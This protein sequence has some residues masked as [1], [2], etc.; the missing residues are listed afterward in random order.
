MSEEKSHAMAINFSLLKS[1]A[2]IVEYAYGCGIRSLMLNSNERA[3][4]VCDC[5]LQ[6]SSSWPELRLYPCIPYPHKYANLVTQKGLL[7]ALTEVLVSESKVHDTLRMLAKGGLGVLEMNVIRLMELLIDVE[8]KMFAGLR[9]EAVFLQNIVTD[10]L[11]GFRMKDAFI[12]Y[13]RYINGKYRAEPGF[14][15]MNMPRLTEFLLESGLDNPL[16]CASINKIG[17]LMNPD[18]ASSEKTI[19]EKKFRPVAMSIFASGAIPAEAAVEYV[20]NQ[21]SIA[22]IVFGASKKEHIRET[23]ILIERF[24]ESPR[25]LRS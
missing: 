19:R 5:L 11:L 23:K 2:D 22:A 24:W 25:E 14:I 21:P 1:I 8:M 4:E 12:S 15:T 17:Y 13:A 18:R 6:N 3:K 7:G 10:L 9:I 20:C 16:V